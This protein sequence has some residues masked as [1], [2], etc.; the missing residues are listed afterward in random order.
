MRRHPSCLGECSGELLS[1]QNFDRLEVDGEIANP[2]RNGEVGIHNLIAASNS[3]DEYGR[4]ADEL[5][6]ND[7]AHNTPSPQ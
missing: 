5:R 1:A 4:C 2:T 6:E 7:F 3:T